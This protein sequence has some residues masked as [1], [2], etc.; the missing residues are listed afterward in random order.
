M[1]P[2]E[3]TVFTVISPKPH[4]FSPEPPK[5]TNLGLLFVAQINAPRQGPR[6]AS[7]SPKSTNLDRNLDQIPII[8]QKPT[9]FT[10]NRDFG[11]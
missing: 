7:K 4:F 8:H 1:I 9:H 3:I 5:S 2:R 10:P 11:G 6:K